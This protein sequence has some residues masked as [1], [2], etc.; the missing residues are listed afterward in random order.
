MMKG[1]QG[2]GLIMRIVVIAIR[3]TKKST[4]SLHGV[5]T[6]GSSARFDRSVDQSSMHDIMLLERADLIFLLFLSHTP[7]PKNSILKRQADEFN[8]ARF[9][10][11]RQAALGTA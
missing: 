10:Q 5:N 3:S 11:R 7:G 2:Q 4:F 9:Q 8:T 1:R 6:S